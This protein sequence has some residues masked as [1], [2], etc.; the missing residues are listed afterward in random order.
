MEKMKSLLQNIRVNNRTNLNH[1]RGQTFQTVIVDEQLGDWPK[2]TG[3][4]RIFAEKKLI[5]SSKLGK[6]LYEKTR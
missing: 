5:T 6:L 1:L 3:F 4:A 2:N